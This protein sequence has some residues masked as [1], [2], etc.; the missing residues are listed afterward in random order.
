MEVETKTAKMAVY[1]D[2]GFKSYNVKRPP[3]IVYKGRETGKSQ[4]STQIQQELW[5]QC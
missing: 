3:H 2:Q 4:E 5:V 1:Y